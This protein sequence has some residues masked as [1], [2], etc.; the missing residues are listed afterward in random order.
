MSRGT[1]EALENVLATLLGGVGG[2]LVSGVL[3]RLGVKP[4]VARAG[5]A[6]AGGA[7]AVLLP[8]RLGC[9]SGGVAAAGVSQL[10]LGFLEA[11]RKAIEERPFGSAGGV[12]EPDAR[13][14]D[15]NPERDGEAG[16]DDEPEVSRERIAAVLR[17][18]LGEP[19]WVL[20]F[21]NGR[22]DEPKKLPAWIPGVAIVA[23]ALMPL[24]LQ[25][26]G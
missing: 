24:L 26:V 22:N 3:V 10:V 21:R 7:G 9:A 4:V 19:Y 23:L 5:V 18:E 11:E 20:R 25:L 1:R 12:T 6:V 14:A 8:G 16:D 2:A 13:N 15:S 17:E